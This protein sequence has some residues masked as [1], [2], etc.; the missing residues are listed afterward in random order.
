MLQQINHPVLRFI[1]TGIIAA[2]LF[3]LNPVLSFAFDITMF[4]TVQAD[5]D[6]NNL[7][8]QVTVQGT[9]PVIEFRFDGPSGNPGQYQ[10][11]IGNPIDEIIPLSLNDILEITVIDQT[12]QVLIIDPNT[13][14]VTQSDI[15]NGLIITEVSVVP[16]PV[17]TGI[18]PGNGP[19]AGGTVV[20]ITGGNFVGGATV[21]IGGALTTGVPVISATQI[22][23]TTPAG[24]GTAVVVV[25]TNPDGQSSVPYAGFTYV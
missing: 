19:E 5:I 12:E 2:C 18:S 9:D 10:L 14:I 25:V 23:A 7:T 13:Y 3:V 16:A 24:T 11:S 21:K 15:D 1:S 6:V 17:V 20:T 8:V 4:V 22:T